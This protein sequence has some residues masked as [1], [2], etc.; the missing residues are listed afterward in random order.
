MAD[1][2][3]QTGPK[4]HTPE[5]LE[6]RKAAARPY[7]GAVGEL[8]QLHEEGKITL[9]P[10]GRRVLLR[11]ILASD[12]SDLTAGVAYDARQ[13]VAHEI[14]AFGPGCPKWWDNEGIPVDKRPRVGQHCWAPS[15][16]IDRASKTDRACRLWSC[17]IDDIAHAW[18]V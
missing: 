3:I 6:R 8:E 11:A 17:K 14:V 5:I 9:L 18:D 2:G 1:D 13:A 12:V 7:V 10:Q 4:W 16:A 15:A